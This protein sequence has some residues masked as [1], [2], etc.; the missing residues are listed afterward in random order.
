MYIALAPSHV[1]TKSRSIGILKGNSA[2]IRIVLVQKGKHSQVIIADMRNILVLNF[3]GMILYY[4]A[5]SKIPMKILTMVSL[6]VGYVGNLN[7]I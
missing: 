2:C 5:F 7:K 4:L 3:M 1:W 6:Q